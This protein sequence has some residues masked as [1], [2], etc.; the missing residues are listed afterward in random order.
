M[1]INVHKDSV[2]SLAT[3]VFG[4]ILI[5]FSMSAY[6]VDD[7]WQ[8]PFDTSSITAVDDINNRSVAFNSRLNTNYDQSQTEHLSFQLNQSLSDSSGFA[9]EYSRAEHQRNTMLGYTANNLSVSIMNGSGEDYSELGGDYSGINAYQFHA[10]LKQDYKYNGYAIDYSIARFGHLQF[11]QV[12]MQADGLLDRKASYFEWSNNRLFARAT[13]FDRGSN[14][15]GNGFDAGFAIGANKQVAYQTMQLDNGASLNR[16]RLQL[17]GNHTRQ[18]WVDLTSHRNP[19]YQDSNDHSIMFSFKTALG[20]KKLVNYAAEPT[21]AGADEEGVEAK[22]SN[23]A[24]KRGIFIG[25]GVAAGLALSS[26]GNDERDDSTTRF[27]QQ[28]DAAFDVLNRV[29]PLSVAENREYGGFVVINPDGSYSPT[30]TVT[31]DNDSVDI[32]FSLVPAGSRATASVHTHSAFDP[33]YD[34]ENFSDTDLE[35]DRNAML[36]GYLATPGGQFKYHNVDTGQVTTLGS[37]AN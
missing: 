8:S 11:G 6:A 36:D 24:L 19:L 5:G 16:I 14:S 33:R 20:A 32:P 4:F 10:G 27:S 3:Q 30:E 18:F 7:F 29:N 1:T 21:V 34:N 37:I 9:I 12:K 28:H 25:V 23:T 26:S 2:S 17:N 35:S 15:I 13:H 31:G 22:K